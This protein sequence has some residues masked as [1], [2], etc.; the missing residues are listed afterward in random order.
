MSI[1]LTTAT[2]DT[3]KELKRALGIATMDVL[4]PNHV[5]NTVN[6]VFPS[7]LPTSKAGIVDFTNFGHFEYMPPLGGLQVN[8]DTII[9][10][11]SLVNL[12]DFATILAL[13]FSGNPNMPLSAINTLVAD[14]PPTT[15][16]ATVALVGIDAVPQSNYRALTAKGYSV[17]I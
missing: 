4:L 6:S 16:I 2:P 11:N 1:E 8:I 7:Y 9:G 10:A 14:L 5:F 12:K 17:V 3:I 15:K 13:D